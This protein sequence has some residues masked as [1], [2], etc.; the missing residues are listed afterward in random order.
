MVCSVLVAVADVVLVMLWLPG[1]RDEVWLPASVLCVVLVT[2]WVL[3]GC[4]VGPRLILAGLDVVLPFAEIVVMVRIEG[5]S[6]VGFV[7]DDV[8]VSVT[9]SAV[10]FLVLV[11]VVDAVVVRLMLARFREVV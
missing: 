11:E 7:A 1:Y 3:V 4:I 2:A 6:V 8:L 5:A 9:L 10:V